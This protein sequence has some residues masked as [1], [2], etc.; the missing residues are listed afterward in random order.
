[1]IIP[2]GHRGSAVGRLPWVTGALIGLCLISFASTPPDTT[3]RSRAREIYLAQAADYFRE[4]AYLQGHG[5]I[6]E[7]MG[8]DGPAD[9]RAESLETLVELTLPHRPDTP[10]GVAAEQSELDRLTA[11]ALAPAQPAAAPSANASRHGGLV[12][13]AVTPLAMISHPFVHTSWLHLLGNML[14]LFVMG[15]ALESRWGRPLYASFYLTAAGVAGAGYASLAPHSTGALLG[16]SGAI[17]GVLGALLVGR[18]PNRLRFAYLAFTRFR[19]RCATFSL[20]AI[21][22]LPLWLAATL[23]G[24]WLAKA[25]PSVL[26]AEFGGLVF[27]VA[28][29]TGARIVSQAQGAGGDPSQ[30]ATVASPSNP[31]LDAALAARTAGDLETACSLLR[32]EVERTPEESEVALAFWDV[33]VRLQRPQEAASAIGHIVEQLAEHGDLELARTHW[34]DLVARVPTQRIGPATLLRLVPLLRE[35]GDTPLV[36]TALRQAVDPHNPGL[37]AGMAMRVIDE[38]GDT[39]PAASL[40]AAHVALSNPDLHESMRSK[41]RIVVSELAGKR[42]EQPP[43]CAVDDPEPARPTSEADDALDFDEV[44]FDAELETDPPAPPLTPIDERRTLAVLIDL[45][46]FAELEVAE[47]IPTRLS[48]DALYLKT[49]KAPK[50]KIEY[51][52]FDAIAVAAAEG[53]GGKPVLLIDLLLNWSDCTEGPLRAVRLRSDTFDA[54]KFTTRSVRPT[55]ALREFTALLLERSRAIPLPDHEAVEGRPFAIYE[56][57]ADYEREVL[58]VER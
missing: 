54:R 14:L 36:L 57:L 21:A 11:R 31:G 43:G 46:R 20:P 49:S 51:S 40:R 41:L 1:M 2:I 3:S 22:A 29:A 27:G 58:Q 42:L 44:D 17:A 28:V 23:V 32:E 5:A 9:Q 24:T 16:A 39:D 53:L 18:G 25:S 48:R 47:A 52:A 34:L 15:P 33:A 10:A 50:A 38:L 13:G 56:S 26:W 30:A 8:N 7:R 45:P 6:L 4:H 19:P 37:S 12:P 55:D 35:H